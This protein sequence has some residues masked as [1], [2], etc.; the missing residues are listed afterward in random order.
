MIDH[1]KIY[2]HKYLFVQQLQIST[3]NIADTNVGRRKDDSAWLHYWKKNT[4][5]HGSFTLSE[6]AAPCNAVFI[7]QTYTSA[8]LLY[9]RVSRSFNSTV[10]AWEICKKF[11]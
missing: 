3:I 8:A 4:E 6:R 1:K 2:L 7:K 11:T 10:S 9:A 5:Y